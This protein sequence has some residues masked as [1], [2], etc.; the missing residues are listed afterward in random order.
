MS[1]WSATRIGTVRPRT[2]RGDRMSEILCPDVISSVGLT[3]D[4]GGVI[5]LFIYGLLEPISKT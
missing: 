1:S 5:L 2:K 4:I 3:L